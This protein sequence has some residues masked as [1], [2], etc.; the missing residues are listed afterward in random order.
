MDFFSLSTSFL[1]EW[2][3]PNCWSPND[4][5]ENMVFPEKNVHFFSNHLVLNFQGPLANSYKI[6]LMLSSKKKKI[7]Y[8]LY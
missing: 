3:C 2:N 1:L 6:Y 8:K 5:F 7:T 4:V